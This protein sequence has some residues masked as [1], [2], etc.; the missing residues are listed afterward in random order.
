MN[1]FLNLFQVSLF[2]GQWHRMH[3]LVDTALAQIVAIG[4]LGPHWVEAKD[5]LLVF[6]V[7]WL[8]VGLLGWG[9]KDCSFGLQ[10][11][12]VGLQQRLSHLEVSKHWAIMIMINRMAFLLSEDILDCVVWA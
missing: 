10:D 9:R 5:M 11:W 7:M 4:L 12:A 2:P 8:V 1:P 3:Q 6:G